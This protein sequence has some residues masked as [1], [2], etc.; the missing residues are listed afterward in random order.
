MATTKKTGRKTP[1]SMDE[2][3]AQL[4]V[5][6]AE[7]HLSIAELTNNCLKAS[8]ELIKL[9][10]DNKETHVG[11][12]QLV[13]TSGS[14]TLSGLKGKAKDLAI[15]KLINQFAK[16]E[17]VE[18]VLDLEAMWGAVETDKKLAKVLELHGLT[19]GLGEPTTYL[20]SVK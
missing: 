14:I 18:R 9:M 12:F 20:K 6:I 13:Q 17:Y 1:L 10:Q 5:K 4:A 15:L 7:L 2:Q 19:V 8:T 11:D 3:M 16:T